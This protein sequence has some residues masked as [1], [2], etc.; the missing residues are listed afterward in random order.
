MAMQYQFRPIQQ[1]PQRFTKNR[2]RATFRV[3]FSDTL[4]LLERELTHLSARNI[5]IQLAVKEAE[6]RLDGMLRAGVKAEHPGVILS[7]DSK[8][9]PLS[10]VCDTFIFPYTSQPDHW[11]A[12]L[13]AI[14]LTLERLRDVTRYGA[15]K[16]GQQYRG[17]RQIGA[18]SPTADSEVL[19]PAMFITTLACCATSDLA[20]REGIDRIYRDLAMKYHPDRGGDEKTMSKITTAIEA[21]RAKAGA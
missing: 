11:Q 14:G 8:H 1:W 2:K 21:L 15:T 7:F 18:D 3:G 10:Y 9:G 19:N 13:R 20:T 12:N 16:S 6:L 5:V 4:K 17:W